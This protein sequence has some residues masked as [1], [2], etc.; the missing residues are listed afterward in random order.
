VKVSGKPS[1]YDDL[2]VFV[3]EQNVMRRFIDASVLKTLQLDISDD[4]VALAVEKIADWM[5]QTGGLYMTN[6]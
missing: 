5:E 3:N 4:N 6:P 2:Q 1:Q